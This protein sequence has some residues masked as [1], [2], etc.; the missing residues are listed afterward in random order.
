MVFLR[1]GFRRREK[2]VCV[3]ERDFQKTVRQLAKDCGWTRGSEQLVLRFPREIYFPQGSFDPNFALETWNRE[4]EQSLFEGWTALRVVG[5]MS[6]VLSRQIEGKRVA[7]YEAEINRLP[8]ARNCV[9]MCQYPSRRLD[10][11]FQL[12][13][14]RVHPKVILGTEP[15][16]NDFY[17]PPG[18]FL[19]NMVPASVL[20]QH[21]AHLRERKRA[22]VEIQEA[23]EY[24]EA[25]VDTVREPMLVLDADLRVVTANYSFYRTFGTEPPETEGKLIYE[26]GQ[27]EWDIPELRKLLEEIVPLNTSFQDYVVEDDFPHI[28]RR[29]MLLNARR[30]HHEDDR[31]QLIL[32]AMEDI[33]ERKRAEERVQCLN[34]MFLTL[35]SDFLANMETVIRTAKEILEADLAAYARLQEGKLTLLTTASGEESFFFLD[36]PSTFLGWSLLQGDREGSLALPDLRPQDRKIKDLL[37]RNNGYSAFLGQI[38]CRDDKPQGV[39]SL[40]YLDQRDFSAEDFETAAILA[41]ALTIEEE[42]LAREEGLKN[43]IDIASHE[44]RHPITL[45]KGYAL[46][47]GERIEH[48]DM[49]EIQ[50]MISAINYGADRL[51]R[52][53]EGFLDLSQIERGGFQL[54]LREVE[55]LPLLEET[56]RE[57]GGLE[58]NFIL[59]AR[60]ELG[61]CCVDAD[62]IKEVMIILL[63]NARKFSNPALP[64]EVEAE[65]HPGE[66]IIS[67]LDRGPGIPPEERGKIF[68]RFYQLEKARYHSKPGIGMGLY[69]AR[70]IVERHHGKIWCEPREGGGSAFRFTIPA[71]I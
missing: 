15:Y 31:K 10:P 53:L 66:Y 1:E 52:L 5:D 22:V 70:E 12:D 32:L 40:Y 2:I 36:N 27:R 44:F 7:E 55:I 57:M 29:V 61:T 60:G 3:G 24:A 20:A 56:L 41:R 64:V 43:F 26:L 4:A 49:E 18:E 17:V 14:L 21:L 8:S 42:R 19:G 71:Q 51:I 11:S 13:M 58:R 28:G 35:G 39:L 65:A 34:R 54:N 67:V 45:I 33:T 63:E 62:R 16:D 68:D 23:R 9:L 6:W 69:I 37:V 47:L 48:L 38:V 46:S 50:E 59:R 30:I 25:I